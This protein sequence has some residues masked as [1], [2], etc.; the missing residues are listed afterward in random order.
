MNLTPEE[1]EEFCVRYEK[2][3]GESITYGK[4]EDMMGQ[5]MELYRV[6]L[7][8]PPPPPPDT[9]LSNL[10]NGSGDVRDFGDIDYVP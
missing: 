7:K 5:L 10:P 3:F 1:I 9:V 4:A 6:I 2:V 8:R